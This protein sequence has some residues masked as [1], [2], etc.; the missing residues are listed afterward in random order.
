MTTQEEYD[1][2]IASLVSTA[3]ERWRDLTGVGMSQTDKDSL[4][5]WLNEFFDAQCVD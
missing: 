4:T 3:D 1:K 5:T 2:F